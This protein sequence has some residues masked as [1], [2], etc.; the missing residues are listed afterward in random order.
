MNCIPRNLF[1]EENH[2]DNL[3]CEIGYGIF[4]DPISLP[5]QHVFCRGCINKISRGMGNGTCPIC[6]E[7][8]SNEQ[9]RGQTEIN[10]LINLSTAK[11]QYCDWTGQ[12]QLYERHCKNDCKAAFATCKYKCVVSISRSFIN[13]H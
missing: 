11:C 2:L 7:I 4:R 6:Y 3:L 13:Q 9:L 8:W 1:V 5:C 12:Y 10:E